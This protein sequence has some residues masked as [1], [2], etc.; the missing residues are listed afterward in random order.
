M[1]VAVLTSSRADYGIYFPLLRELKNDIFFELELVVFGTHLSENFGLTIEQII[2]DGFE[3]FAKIETVPS[4]NLPIDISSEIGNTIVKFANFWASN[5]YDLVFCLGDRYE[6][7]AAC[8]ASVPFNVRLAHIHGGEKTTGAIDDCFRHS[9]THMASIHFAASSIYRDRV[10]NLKESKNNVYNVGSLSI[11]NLK[12][13]KLLSLS[14]FYSKFNIDLSIKSILITFHP[15]TVSYEKNIVYI[16]NLIDALYQ[17]NGYQFIITMPNADTMGLVI[18]EKLSQ[19]INNSPYAIG[20][21]SFGTIAYLSCMK[22]CSFLLGNT[23]SGFIEASY[24]PKPVINLGKRQNGRIVTPNI[25]NCEIEK[26]NILDV[27]KQIELS[28]KSS[29][30]DIYGDGNTAKSIVSILKSM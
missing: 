30:I 26:E 23:S 6:M 7:F 19:F 24:F 18:R 14:E 15:E 9:I 3:V 11:D 28:E 5:S 8:A 25:I 10:I 29:K 4:G 27:V 21:E 20:I 16:Q 22:Y 12:N 1:K 17:I 13:L 2:S